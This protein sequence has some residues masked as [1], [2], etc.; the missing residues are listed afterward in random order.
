MLATELFEIFFDVLD[1]NPDVQQAALADISA[2]RE[3]VRLLKH[4]CSCTPF[5]SKMGPCLG[6]LSKQGAHMQHYE[7]AW[8]VLKHPFS[9][10]PTDIAIKLRRASLR[11]AF[12]SIS[13][14]SKYWVIPSSHH[15][16]EGGQRLDTGQNCS[17]AFDA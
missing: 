14:V 9:A 5:P 6:K 17:T 2:V 16:L 7:R 8:P 10:S 11:N 12:L 15:K 13:V 4:P 3:R 1:Q